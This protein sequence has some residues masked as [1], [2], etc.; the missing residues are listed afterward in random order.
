M[1]QR[2]S[3]VVWRWRAPARGRKKTPAARQTG[4]G[5]QLSDVPFLDEHGVGGELDEDV[6]FDPQWQRDDVPESAAEAPDTEKLSRLDPAEV[7]EDAVTP[8]TERLV[9]LYLQEAGA[10]PL[11][12]AADE[13]RLAEQLHTAKARLREALQAALLSAGTP[14]E[15]TPEAWLGERLRQLQCWISRLDQGHVADVETDSGLQPADLRQLWAKLQPWQ[16]SLEAAKAA[17][18]TAN[19]R[20]VVA[21]TKRFVNR[22]L[23]LLDLIQE[24]NLGLMRAVE[25]FDPQRGFRLST[26]AGWWIRQAIGRAL[27][28]QTRTVR[29]PSHVSERLGQLS[30][31]AQRLRQELAREPTVPELAEVLHLSVAQVH[32]M[33]ARVA[34]ILSL[35]MTVADRQGQLGNLLAER[36]LRDLSDTAAETELREHVRRGLQA[37]TPREAYIVRSRFG[38]D[39]NQGQTLEEIGRALRLSRERVR[40]IEASGL[41][42]LRRVMCQRQRYRVLER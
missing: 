33:Q 32:A 22:G 25:K 29:I 27:A 9:L 20:L 42:K 2:R 24:G 35:D 39:T 41:E 34:P 13:V 17:M 12:T 3:A 23:P 11:L 37:L 26:Y 30:R 14:P 16:E 5:Q 19:L 40:Q 7:A 38:L 8:D 15:V 1:S 6:S 4:E 31:T 18:V 10:V 36:P 28:E 21:I